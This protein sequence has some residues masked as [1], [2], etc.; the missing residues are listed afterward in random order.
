MWSSAAG[1]AARQHLLQ[2]GCCQTHPAQVPTQLPAAWRV[3]QLANPLVQR[4]AERP[5]R[6]GLLLA[7]AQAP[8]EQPAQ[9]G[10]QLMADLAG[11]QGRVWGWELMQAGCL[12]WRAW[13]WRLRERRKGCLWLADLHRLQ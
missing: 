13:V 7:W 8:Q 11:E 12:S 9:A 10:C 3:R 1:A 6:R 4:A 2:L 5:G